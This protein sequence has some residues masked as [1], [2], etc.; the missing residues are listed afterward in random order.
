MPIN[1]I[2]PENARQSRASRRNSSSP[3]GVAPALTITRMSCSLCLSCVLR[4]S[5]RLP[6]VR[7]RAAH[8]TRRPVGS[9]VGREIRGRTKDTEL[10][11]CEVA[12]RPFGQSVE[13][14]VS[15]ARAVVEGADRDR[16]LPRQRQ[17]HD[18]GRS[19]GST[20]PARMS[21][22]PQRYPRSSDLLRALRFAATFSPRGP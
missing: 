11:L 2:S 16:P 4:P 9:C 1:H 19:R 20:S 21:A 6:D 14:A 8:K 15:R 10:S 5:R 7:E 13:R 17:G 22:A 12:R 3:T 18:L